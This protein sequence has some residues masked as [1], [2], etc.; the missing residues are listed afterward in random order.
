MVPYDA[1]DHFE[2]KFFKI[3]MQL[4]F[5]SDASNVARGTVCYLRVVF[6]NSA[7]KCSLVMAKT[8]VSGA[9]R[10]TIPRAELEAALDAVKVSRTIKQE[11]DIPNCPVF[12]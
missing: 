7:V 1:G 10:T 12:F 6:L 2:Q 11:L 4:H 5:F 8:H 9:G 3:Q